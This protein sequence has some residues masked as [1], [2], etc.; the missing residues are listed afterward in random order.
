MAK[1]GGKSREAVGQCERHERTQAFDILMLLR[2]A[3]PRSGE[4]AEVTACQFVVLRWK[5]N[6]RKP[7]AL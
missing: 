2:V 1:V 6:M 3:D 5:L 4:T 7:T